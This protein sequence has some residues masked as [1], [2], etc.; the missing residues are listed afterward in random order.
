MVYGVWYVV[1]GIYMV[2]G[3]WCMLYGVWMRAAVTAVVLLSTA[4]VLQ[5]QPE[6]LVH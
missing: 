3:V 2:H 6:A 4:V 5:V 1:H